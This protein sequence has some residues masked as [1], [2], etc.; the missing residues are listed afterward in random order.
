M[1][2]LSTHDF[3]FIHFA[4]NSII[5]HIL[6]ENC[7]ALSHKTVCLFTQISCREWVI[8]NIPKDIGR[9]FCFPGLQHEGQV[10]FID[11]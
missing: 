11:Y 9:Q 3:D 5:I 6:A 10:I 2:F 1:Q 4:N 7:N 8:K